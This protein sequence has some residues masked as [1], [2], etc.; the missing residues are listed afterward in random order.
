VAS[1]QRRNQGTGE[2]TCQVIPQYGRAFFPGIVLSILC[3]VW[4]FTFK[5]VLEVTGK[6]FLPRQKSRNQPFLV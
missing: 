2:F 3:T 5:I 6:V 1:E 4:R